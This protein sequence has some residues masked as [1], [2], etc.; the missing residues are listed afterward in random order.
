MK[1]L[2]VLP[3]YGPDVRGGI[4]TFYN[5]L[6]P[7]IAKAGCQVGVCVAVETPPGVKG[8]QRNEAIGQIVVPPQVVNAAWKK[9]SHFAASPAARRTLALA[10]AAWEACAG[11]S[12]YDVVE[13]TDFGLM[14]AP[15]LAI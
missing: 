5:H 7:A 3:E 8:N 14:F 12:A 2:Y 13:T 11:G 1:I 6:L 10:Y 9:L 15:W 4:A